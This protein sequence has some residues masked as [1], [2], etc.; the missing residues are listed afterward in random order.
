MTTQPLSASVAEPLKCVF[1]DGNLPLASDGSEE[2]VFL[3]SLG[4][5]LITTRAICAAC[6]NAFST[7]ETEFADAVVGQFFEA[8]RNF[9]NIIS[10]RKGPPPTIENLQ[11]PASGDYFDLAPG[12]TPV[13]RKFR[14]PNKEVMIRGSEHRLVAS[15]EAEAI[16]AREIL[17]LRRI[18][19]EKFLAS[20]ATHRVGPMNYRMLMSNKSAAYRSIAKTAIVAGV[21]LFGNETIRDKVST[22]L[23]SSARYGREQVRS[24][25]TAAVTPDWPMLLNAR[26]H[27]DS[28]AA[29]A[30]G[31]EHSAVFI[32]VRDRWR[33]YLAFFGGFRFCVDLGPASGLPRRSLVVNPRSAVHARLDADI[34]VPQTIPD[35]AA[36]A[37]Q[38][39]PDIA[40]E[41]RSALDRVLTVCYQEGARRS[42][43]L[44]AKELAN[45]LEEA[46]EDEDARTAVMARHSQ[47]IA[48]IDAGGVWQ[49]PLD[50]LDPQP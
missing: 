3:S 5:R 19:V 36:L 49:E 25:V 29:T 39:D 14:I 48:T 2:H 17:A 40:A 10:G 21:V 34:G 18:E 1:C 32:D 44:R 33:A 28:P 30:S 4:G 8:P 23:R 11:D 43:E 41:F 13:P 45:E 50:F 42:D 6:N 15:T 16:R 31:F 20:S 9:L 27:P 24:L 37:A 7:G 38:H 22:D 46:G 12:M 26:A 35:I 47:K